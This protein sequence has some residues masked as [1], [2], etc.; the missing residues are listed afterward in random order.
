MS[1]ELRDYRN[2]YLSPERL[3]EFYEK[4]PR[5]AA[6]FGVPPGLG[7]TRMIE[8]SFVQLNALYPRIHYA[9]SQ[10]RILDEM[11]EKVRRL[12]LNH[13]L[14]IK[15]DASLCGEARDAEWFQLYRLKFSWMGKIAIC[16]SCPQKDSCAWYETI[17]DRGVFLILQSQDHLLANL[18]AV[19]ENSLTIFDELKFVERPI[20]HKVTE[21]ELIRYKKVLS[22]YPQLLNLFLYTEA[23]IGNHPVDLTKLLPEPKTPEEKNK[24]RSANFRFHRYLVSESIQNFTPLVKRHTSMNLYRY[25]DVIYFNDHP[26]VPGALLV[27]GYGANRNLLEH[28]FQREFHDLTPK[29]RY[30]DPGTRFYQLASS[31]T[32]Y[33]HFVRSKPSRDGIYRMVAAKIHA[34]RELG[35]K[36]LLV[37]KKGT[38]PL[39]LSELPSYFTGQRNPR[40]SSYAGN[41]LLDF[42]GINVIPLLHY[43]VEG[44]N[45]FESYDTVICLNAYNIKPEIVEGQLRQLGVGRDISVE[46]E[47]KARGMGREITTEPQIEVAASVFDY[48]E[49]HKIIQTVSRARPFNSPTEV[50]LAGFQ[51]FEFATVFNDVRDLADALQV[52][53]SIKRERE[54]KELSARGLKVKEIAKLMGLSERTIA[55]YRRRAEKRENAR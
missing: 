33:N 21:A 6:L 48:L 41:D 55:R 53:S 46:I 19:P 37:A 18:S 28:I 40:F 54:V 36:T 14:K 12:E 44:V 20:Q 24:Y 50:I 34:N 1:F 38:I 3:V 4:N 11:V 16:G 27:T 7:K 8:D 32:S 10:H 51:D 5:G 23:L 15:R 29:E 26:K 43:G 22:K 52:G 2:R 13:L 30:I 9:A 42:D 31:S 47:H 35:K 49:R 25:D 17:D 39:I 45:T